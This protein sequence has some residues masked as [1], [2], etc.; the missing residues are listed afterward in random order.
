MSVVRFDPGFG[1]NGGPYVVQSVYAPKLNYNTEFP[2]LGSSHGPSISAEHQP[3]LLPQHLPRQWSAPSSSPG[4]IAYG[5]AMMTSF[6]PNHVTARPASA[7]CWHSAQHPGQ[8][9]V[10]K[11][12]HPRE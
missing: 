4:G 1:F 2:Q 3:R 9:P 5:H 8:H 6:N 12:I 11:F 10:A 7:L